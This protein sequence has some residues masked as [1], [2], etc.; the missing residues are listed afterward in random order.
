MKVLLLGDYS[1]Y[2][3][4]LAPALKALGHDVTVA[5]DGTRWMDTPRDIDL[6]RRRS[7][8]GGALM[9]LRLN[10]ILAK[11]L[12]GYDIVQVNSPCFVELRPRRLRE[13]LR[14]LRRDNGR[15]FLS[16]LGTDSLLVKAML[17]ENP[18]LR[19]S[20]WHTPSG[21]SAWSA[22]DAA[23]R[24]A[25][26]AP[27]LADYTDEFYDSISGAAT[28]LYEYHRV[29]RAMRPELPLAYAGIPVDI[30]DEAPRHRDKDTPL[31][32]LFAA[33][34]ARMAEKGADILLQMLTGI[35][36][37]HQGSFELLTPPNMPYAAFKRTLDG[38][39]VVADQLYSYTPATTA[40]M[41]MARG[42]VPISGGEEDFYDFIGEKELRPII[43]PDPLDLDDTYCRL[44]YF[45][46]HP[47][48]VAAMQRQC[49]TFVERHNSASVVA[50][51]IAALW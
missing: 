45:L 42:A 29:L 40:L 18:P 12:R 2:H 47:G 25:W 37:A 21:P 41:A 33:H 10:T 51:R 7:K 43:N 46:T 22:S 49:R 17:G 5:S 14:R 19:Y 16:A 15:I 11:N 24:D 38:V 30:P 13:L 48:A 9:W 20:E 1:G 26:L 6:S 39:D 34:A 28:A 3:A 23:Q 35:A 4:T 44:E 31:R 8:A 27:E 32:V 36:A 50:A